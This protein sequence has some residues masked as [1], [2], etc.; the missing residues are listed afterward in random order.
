[1]SKVCDIGAKVRTIG[2][3]V[4]VVGEERCVGLA[5]KVSGIGG[6]VRVIGAKGASNWRRTSVLGRKARSCWLPG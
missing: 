2:G 3:K 5:A 6:K 1:V 4:R